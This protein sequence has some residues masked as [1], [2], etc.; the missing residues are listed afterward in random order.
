MFLTKKIQEYICFNGISVA[1][2]LEKINNNKSRIVFVV[3]DK[4]RLLGSLS[5]GDI[6]RWLIGTDD[7]DLTLKVKHVMNESVISLRVSTDRQEIKENFLNGIDC[8]PMVDE[9]NHLVQ[10]AFNER[11]GFFIGN[12]EISEKSPSFIIAEIGNNHQGCIK[13]AKELVDHA[14]DANVD[15]VKFQMRSMDKLYKNSGELN[16]D[17]VDL[18]AQYTLDLLSRFQL[19]NHEL[20]EVF[21]YAKSKA[22]IPLCTPWDVDSLTA[23][24][25]YGMEAY[26][27]A[28][29]DF[30]NFEL[31]EAIAN[32]GKPFFCS[33][34]MST[35]GEIK[36]TVRF[37]DSLG[38]NYVLLHCNST[39][40]TPFKDVN[41]NY[42]TRLKKITG[43]LVGYSGH[44][45]GIFIPIASIALGACVIEKHLT[46]DKSLEGTDHKVSLL[47]EELRDMVTK[48][49]QVEES[50]G[51]DDTP[52]EITQGELLNRENLAK[53]LVATKNIK[54]GWIITR[55]MIEIKSPGQGLQPNR[56][57]DLVGKVA[58]RDIEASGFFYNTDII[59]QIIKRN[60]NF[61][62][63]FG[64]PVRY[65]DF[66]AIKEGT[67]LDFVEFHLSYNDL[68]IKLEKYFGDEELL[69]FAVHSPELFEN[70]H[71]LDLGSDDEQYRAHS[72]V[73]LT[74]VVSITRSLKKYFPK[75]TSPVIVLNAGGWDVNGFISEANKSIKYQLISDSLSQIDLSGVTIAIQTMPPFPWHFGGQSFHNLFVC[76][77]EIKVFCSQNPNIK[78]CLDVSHSMMACN[79]Y[80]WDLLN[81]VEKI[82][83]YNVH[84]HIV[85]AKGS[86]GEGVK[87]GEGDVD[88][89]AL[90]RL[91]NKVNEKVQFIPEVW[92]GH[93]NNGEG[94]WS[95]LEFLE[96]HDV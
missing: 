15:C 44:E 67:N 2:A 57:D 71:I 22:I 77:D 61:S 81:F 29:A 64:V 34:G 74:E 50:L 55:D 82:A 8:I 53:S 52:R 18:G 62:R 54:N 80:G 40:P 76:A 93:K 24:E 68:K 28:S 90:F 89:H 43:Q 75:T 26:K 14:V 35:E 19:T 85:D 11:D 41:L 63:P 83:P 33:T 86:D 5:D 94:F 84:M 3:S 49:R 31:L 39:Y 88:F 1:D 6:R 37:L 56:I 45:R 42:I 23:L 12:K 36:Q 32:T 4:G 73:L 65:H 38:S 72:I 95:G 25:S 79:Y 13:L 58:N 87:I 92:Q 30:T 66:H 9:Y 20:M 59:G 16:D 7:L 10:L 27:V 46:V 48:I 91:L 21:D 47:P 70:D 96:S 17:S 69:G 60:Y 51:T 78:I